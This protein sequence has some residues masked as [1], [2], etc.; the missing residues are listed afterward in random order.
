M[1]IRQHRALSRHPTGYTHDRSRLGSMGL[2]GFHLDSSMGDGIMTDIAKLLREAAYHLRGTDCPLSLPEALDVAAAELESAKPTFSDFI[3]GEDK[4]KA[5]LEVLD[6]VQREQLSV[7]ESAKP[8]T[9]TC[10]GNRDPAY[11][12]N[13]PGNQI[14]KNHGG[15][16]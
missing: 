16:K 12:C 9:F 13:R 7:L 3:R 14:K 4:E 1:R 2:A 6:K 11:S 15:S 8:V 5:M 10:H